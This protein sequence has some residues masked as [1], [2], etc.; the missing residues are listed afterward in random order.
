[1]ATP[2]SVRESELLVADERG[3]EMVTAIIAKLRFV[4]AEVSSISLAF[5]EDSSHYAKLQEALTYLNEVDEHLYEAKR[6]RE[7]HS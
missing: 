3:R 2:R 5:D 1:M 4:E 6:S 7:R